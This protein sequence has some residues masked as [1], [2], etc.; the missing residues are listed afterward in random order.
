VRHGHGLTALMQKRLIRWMYCV[1]PCCSRIK[2]VSAKYYT[3]LRPKHARPVGLI[4][5]ANPSTM[6]NL[7]R[8]GDEQ[9]EH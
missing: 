7:A 9:K 6:I 5:A 1:P 8:A 3:A 4:I 2:D